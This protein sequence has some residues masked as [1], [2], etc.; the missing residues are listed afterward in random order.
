MAVGGFSPS[1]S[2]R[3]HQCTF[4]I[5]GLTEFA[6]VELAELKI[7][8]THW[9]CPSISSCQ[10]SILLLADHPS[11]ESSHWHRIGCHSGSC[12]ERFLG[13]GKRTVESR[14]QGSGTDFIPHGRDGE[15]VKEFCETLLLFK[16]WKYTLGCRSIGRALA[17]HPG[18]SVSDP[19]HHINQT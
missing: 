15:I 3:K 17:Q 1:N 2:E 6:Q 5:L 16:H 11:R 7:W 9:V 12:Q 10:L 19:W 14:K 18:R 8:K 4:L 13:C